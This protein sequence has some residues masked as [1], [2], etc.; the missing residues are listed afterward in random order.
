MSV[1]KV[2]CIKIES[3]HS[4]NSTNLGYLKVTGSESSVDVEA[5]ADTGTRITVFKG[6]MLE[7]ITWEDL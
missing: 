4:I 1:E 7:D 2:H 6:T 3:V 5:E